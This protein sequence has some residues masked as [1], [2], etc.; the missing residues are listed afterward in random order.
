MSPVPS[1]CPRRCL[2]SLS[3]IRRLSSCLPLCRGVNYLW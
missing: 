3:R 2:W 1:V